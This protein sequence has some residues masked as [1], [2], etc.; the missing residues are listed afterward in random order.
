MQL[1]D[2]HCHIDLPEFD[3]DREQVLTKARR[4]GVEKIIVP[5]ITQNRW[6]ALLHICNSHPELYS[7]V[8]LHPIYLAEHKQADLQLLESIL[9]EVRVIAIGEIGLDFYVKDLNQADQIKL[10]KAQLAI[11]KTADLPVILHCRKAYD[12]LIKLLT[13]YQL[14]G[15]I[16]HAFNGSLQQANKLIDL[17]YK[18]GF[19]GMLTYQRSTK[20]RKL[21]AQLP[22]ESIVLET[23]SPFMTVS[24]YQGQRN[25]P[26]YLPYVL[27]SF[28]EIRKESA[29][30][31]S[32]QTYINALDVFAISEL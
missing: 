15:G 11:A 24:Q 13:R 19:G 26:A 10:L 23:D 4:E 6:S 25:S 16:A 1:F 18:L 21:A 2:T 29:S 5:A 17:G 30:E 32:R 3:Y 22:L 31:I 28:V 20:L 9:T 12:D 27:Q 7:A 8:G 14:R